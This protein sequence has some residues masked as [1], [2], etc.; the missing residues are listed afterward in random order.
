MLA[1]TTALAAALAATPLLAQTSEPAPPG[2]GGL[3]FGVKAGF[4]I[5]PDQ[6]VIGVQYSLGKSLGVFR[7]V[8]NA[9]LG[10]GDG[11]TFDINFD[12]LLRLI[13]KDSGFGFY[14][15][16]APTFITGEGD[17]DFGLTLVGGVQ[18]PIIKNQATNIE[19]RFGITDHVPDFRILLSLIL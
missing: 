14:G 6:F 10:F 13:A 15:G 16:A 12:F 11:T 8:P 4:G 1:T 17:S 19:A 5:D 7:L 9:H 2:S 18:V 3:G